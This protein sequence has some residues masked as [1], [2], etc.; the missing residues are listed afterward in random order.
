MSYMILIII[1]LSVIVLFQ[2]AR[3]KDLKWELE[4][5]HILSDRACRE[6]EMYYE[7]ELRN[8]DYVIECLKGDINELS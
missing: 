8:R 2:T 6:L 4:Q 3:V 1:T 7:Q 5:D